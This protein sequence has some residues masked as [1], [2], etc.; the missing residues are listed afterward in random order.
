MNKVLTDNGTL[1]DVVEV[2][3]KKNVMA[4]MK[5]TNSL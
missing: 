5:W 4:E 3:Y 1:L 2:G